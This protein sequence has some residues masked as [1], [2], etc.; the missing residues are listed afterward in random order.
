V[1]KVQRLFCILLLLVSFL[2]AV[3]QTAVPTIP[4]TVIK[5]LRMS[6]AMSMI[7]GSS[8]GSQ[9]SVNTEKSAAI[10]ANGNVVLDSFSD[11]FGGTIR[12]P[13]DIVLFLHTHPINGDPRP[14]EVDVE[15]AKKLGVPNCAVSLKQV[16]CA[17]PDGRIEQIQ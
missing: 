4:Q 11:R 17:M 9:D 1:K 6:A 5:H 8:M 15:T 10:E 7:G 16:W 2:P 14:S 13:K 3:A 12:V